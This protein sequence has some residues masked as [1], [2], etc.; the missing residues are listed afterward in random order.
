MEAKFKPFVSSIIPVIKHFEIFFG[1]PKLYKI[2]VIISKIP[3]VSNI[4]KITEN[5]TIK[6]PIERIDK[7]AFFIAFPKISP[8][9]DNFIGVNFELNFDS[10]KFISSLFFSKI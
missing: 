4:D 10:L 9:S 7:I 1:S 6:P 3:D 5:S 8:K 2:D